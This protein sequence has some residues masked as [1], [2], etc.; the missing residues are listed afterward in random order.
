[1]EL[2]YARKQLKW[3]AEKALGTLPED[4]H[5]MLL[6]HVPIMPDSVTSDPITN[7]DILKKILNAF[8][9]KIMEPLS[10]QWRTSKPL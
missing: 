9:K 5:V 1:M 3:I 10:Q 7:G 2:W 4:Y 8:V 6:S